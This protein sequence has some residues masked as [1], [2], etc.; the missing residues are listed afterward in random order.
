LNDTSSQADLPSHDFD[1][2]DFRI[3]CVDDE[4]NILSSLRRMFTLAGIPVYV[5]PSG[6]EAL[7]MLATQ[8]FHLVLS[9]MLMPEM[10]GA[11]LLA[12]VRIQ[13]PKIMRLMLTGTIELTD[14]MSAVSQGEVH[15]CLTKPWVDEEL[16]SAVQEALEIYARG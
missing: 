9:D 14:A 8:E 13:Y 12:Q 11:E 3:L 2:S 15:Q 7:K 16:I 10:N 5:A 1:V 6:A 4:P